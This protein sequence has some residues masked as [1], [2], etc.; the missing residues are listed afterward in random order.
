MSQL[1][2][3]V[4]ALTLGTSCLAAPDDVARNYLLF[5]YGEPGIDGAKICHPHPDL[6][7]VPG[8][9]NPESIREA[10]AASKSITYRMPIG[11]KGFELTLVKKGST[12]KIDSS[13]KISVPLKFFFQ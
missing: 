1:I 13:K 8:A 11:E 6:W 12:W 9:K 2:V 10:K 3:A 7:M 5:M 4:L